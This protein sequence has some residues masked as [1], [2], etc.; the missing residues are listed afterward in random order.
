M[1]SLL[2]ESI[3]LIR[4][5]KCHPIKPLR[6]F[7]LSAIKEAFQHFATG[8][9]IGKVAID[10]TSKARNDMAPI[11]VCLHAYIITPSAPLNLFTQV[12]PERYRTT[13]D[14]YKSYL[15]VGCLGGL[16]R[17][18]TRWMISRGARSFT[19]LSRSGTD[20]PAAQALI[21]ELEDAGAK[22]K[23][24]RGDVSSES[25]VLAAIEAT[26][27]PIGGVIQA[28]MTLRVRRSLHPDK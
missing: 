9:R 25:A 23:V 22:T 13:F 10:F 4:E 1:S 27:T 3:Q 24:I 5:Q 18:I 26:Q 12:Q 6:V 14:S 20:K 19:F 21:A 15:L 11:E 28:A 2:Q 16:G 7:D 17:H 8:D